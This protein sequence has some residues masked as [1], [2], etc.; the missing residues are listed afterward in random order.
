MQKLWKQPE[1]TI[2]TKVQAY[3]HNLNL[4][5][6]NWTISKTWLPQNLFL[7]STRVEYSFYHA[8][9]DFPGQRFTDLFPQYIV[10]FDIRMRIILFVLDLLK[11]S[12]NLIWGKASI[13]SNPYFREIA[14]FIVMW[15]VLVCFVW[16][17]IRFCTV[18]SVGNLFQRIYKIWYVSLSFEDIDLD[19]L[20]ITGIF[21]M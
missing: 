13:V 12:E 5:R 6:T 2:P 17:S 1:N 8:P 9:L 15:P 7:N 3:S 4:T 10:T 14:L 19:F 11:E 20:K 18:R 21:V 16:N